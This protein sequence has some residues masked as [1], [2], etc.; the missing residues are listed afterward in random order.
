MNSMSYEEDRRFSRLHM[1]AVMTIFASR[2]LVQTIRTDVHSVSNVLLTDNVSGGELVVSSLVG[3]IEDMP[4]TP[5]TVD[6]FQVLRDFHVVPKVGLGEC[7]KVRILASPRN[8]DDEVNVKIRTLHINNHIT[9]YREAEIFTSDEI[10][11]ANDSIFDFFRVL[12]QHLHIVDIGLVDG[13]TL[14]FICLG[15]ASSIARQPTR[16]RLNCRS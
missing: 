6:N 15:V 10:D 9:T 5:R 4:V 3:G 13:I 12:F 7:E 16:T 11:E 14:F 1:P 2:V 8:I